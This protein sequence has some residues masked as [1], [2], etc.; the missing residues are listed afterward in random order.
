MSGCLA[1]RSHR[2]DAGDRALLDKRS[3]KGPL[4]VGDGPC[5]TARVRYRRTG[6]DAV[7]RQVAQNWRPGG[8]APRGA[9]NRKLRPSGAVRADSGFEVATWQPSVNFR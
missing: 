6:T 9:N 5:P 7:S 2:A 8:G 3:A 1:R 4:V